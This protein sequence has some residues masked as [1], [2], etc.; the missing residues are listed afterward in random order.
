MTRKSP[1]Q[2]RLTFSVRSTRPLETRH[3]SDEGPGRRKRRARARPG[4]EDPPEPPRDGA[5]LRARATRAWPASPTACPIDTSNI[6]EVADFAQ[7]IKARPHRGRARAAHGA[8]HRRRVPAPRASPSSA[9]AGP[10]PRSRAPRPS[11]ASSCSGT[12]SP[13]RATRSAPRAE[14]AQDFVKRAPF[15]YPVVIKADGLASG[16]GTIVAA[17]RGR[18]ARRRWP[19]MMSDKKF[20]T[21][22]A[23]LVMEE[24]LHGE[25]V[26]FLVFSDGVARRAHGLRAGPQARARRRQGRRTPAGMGTV[27]PVHQ[28]HPRRA[29]A[30]HA[31]D[32]PAHR[33]GPGRGGAASTRACSTPG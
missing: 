13:R 28:P 33:R 20:G 2:C 18:G 23:K 4:L 3:E 10:P 26:S 15:G 25:E 9:R 22:G 14:A 24:F 16:K 5:L 30:D 27:S 1:R 6:V 7:T 29:Q 19:Q 11:P 8:G 17:G 12:R 31:G 21:P 32:H